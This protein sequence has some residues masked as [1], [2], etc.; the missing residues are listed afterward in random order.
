MLVQFEDAAVV[1]TQSFPDRVTALHGGIERTDPGFAALH[2]LTVD[3]YDQVAVLRVKFLQHEKKEGLIRQTEK[4]LNEITCYF[5]SSCFPNSIFSF[6]A[7]GADKGSHNI[8]GIARKSRADDREQ[9]P[10]SVCAVG[11]MSILP[12]RRT[13]ISPRCRR[14]RASRAATT[15]SILRT[16]RRSQHTAIPKSFA[17]SPEH[18]AR[19]SLAEFF[20]FVCGRNR[21]SSVAGRNQDLRVPA[22]DSF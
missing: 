11:T 12:L 8:R 4:E 3:V 20:Q 21:K 10:L 14:S 16:R 9:V 22:L 19:Q 6:S 17:D 18:R 1:K 7:V 2:Q 5:L 13:N 15:T